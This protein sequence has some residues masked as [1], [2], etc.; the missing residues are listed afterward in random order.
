M[1]CCVF[2]VINVSGKSMLASPLNVLFAT[3]LL[4]KYT[5]CIDIWEFIQDRNPSAVLS[6]QSRFPCQ[7][8]WENIWEF[9]L[10][11]NPTAALFVTSHLLCQVLW[12]HTWEFILER[13]LSIAPCEQVICPVKWLAETFN[14]TQWWE[15]PQLQSVYKVICL[16]VFLAETFKDSRW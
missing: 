4:E 3:S 14:S 11:R 13:N 9:T 10:E 6:A 7:A 16:C 1:L 2:T 12:K 5:T 8:N 15:G